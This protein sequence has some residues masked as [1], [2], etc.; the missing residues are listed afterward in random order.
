MTPTRILPI[1]S[2]LS[3]V[4]VEYGGYA[5]LSL[6]TSAGGLDAFQEQFFRAGHAHAGV[7]LVLSLVYFILLDQLPRR[8]PVDGGCGVAGRDHQP[9][10]RLLLAH[11]QRRA[12]R[13]LGRNHGDHHRCRPH[14]RLTDHAGRRADQ[15][16]TPRLD[17]RCNHPVAP[18]VCRIAGIT[19]PVEQWPA[20]RTAPSD[21]VVSVHGW[22]TVGIS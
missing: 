19:S 10:R 22:P 7:L 12:G 3:L 5:L 18:G 4:T 11:A 21:Q 1:A 2:I 20:S 16:G 14:R 15:V 9:V 8:G 17:T 13:A 6:L